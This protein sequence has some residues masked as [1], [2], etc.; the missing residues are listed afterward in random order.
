MQSKKK[1]YLSDA[2]LIYSM[3]I[4]YVL[5]KF[6]YT[7]NKSLVTHKVYEKNETPS[8]GPRLLQQNQGLK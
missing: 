2:F 4:T 1:I 6:D 3:K 7:I 5:L 8:Q